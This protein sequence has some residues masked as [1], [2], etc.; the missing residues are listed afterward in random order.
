MNFLP[1]V[2]GHGPRRNF[3]GGS[4]QWYIHAKNETNTQ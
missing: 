4:L 2:I 3:P 1:E